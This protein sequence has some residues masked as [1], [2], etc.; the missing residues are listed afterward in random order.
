MTTVAAN[1]SMCKMSIFAR[2]ASI[3]YDLPYHY[4]AF[5]F[6]VNMFFGLPTNSFVL[7]LSM[8]EIIRGQSTEIFI[9]NTALV[10]IIFSFA[11]ILVILYYFFRCMACQ[12]PTIT[13]GLIM[14]V[15]RP[16]FQSCICVER[17][18]GVAHPL[19]FLKLKPMKYRIACGVVGWMAIVS[20]C[21][22]VLKDPFE[23]Y[24]F[25]LPGYVA[26]FLIKLYTCSMV[27]KALVRPGPRQREAV[28]RDK[29][30]AF[31]IMQIVLVSSM[32]TYIPVICSL[33]LYHILVYERFL[34][35]WSISLSTGIIMGF[36]QPF[37]YLRKVGKLSLC[38]SFN[39]VF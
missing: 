25:L 13:L 35:Y 30:K 24:M 11:F 7:W 1:A 9:F 17:Y 31:R 14:L 16:L 26:F 23:M 38:F 8:K 5:S 34:W 19:T 15:G 12:I 4:V 28:N 2:N 20:S 18:L 37:L 39:N 6:G 27:L 21:L 36:V 10:E 32:F 22:T 33:V 29:I 3:C